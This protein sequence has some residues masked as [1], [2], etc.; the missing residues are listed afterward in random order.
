MIKND[1][2][3][4]KNSSSKITLWL[5]ARQA[6]RFFPIT[7]LVISFTPLSIWSPG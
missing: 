2:Y 5:L 4:D 7:F 1:K 6:G 3:I